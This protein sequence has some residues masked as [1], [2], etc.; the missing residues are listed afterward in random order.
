MTVAPGT[1]NFQ[2]KHDLICHVVKVKAGMSAHSMVDV[3][4]SPLA[5]LIFPLNPMLRENQRKYILHMIK[6]TI[7]VKPK[8]NIFHTQSRKQY[9]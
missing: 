7:T 6:K 9:L 3:I 8:E 5:Y 1:R 4:P 2:S